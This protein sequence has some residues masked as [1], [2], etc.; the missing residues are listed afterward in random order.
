MKTKL[1]ILTTTLL[2][3]LTFMHAQISDLKMTNEDY[4]KVKM[5]KDD[6][7]FYSSDYFLKS[8]ENGNRKNY[9]DKDLS[10]TTEFMC[11]RKLNNNKELLKIAYFNNK[12]EYKIV[13]AILENYDCNKRTVN[14]NSID[15]LNLKTGTKNIV[16][17]FENFNPKGIQDLIANGILSMINMTCK[18]N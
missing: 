3:S 6:T 11:F 16:P 2:L 5:S 8:I 4:D 1:I 9:D 15:V 10:N 18:Q 12:A 17:A 14:I 7:F 13:Y